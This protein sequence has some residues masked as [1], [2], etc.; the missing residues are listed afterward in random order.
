MIFEAVLHG[1][2]YYFGQRESVESVIYIFEKLNARDSGD[3]LKLD[4]WG[5]SRNYLNDN[6]LRLVIKQATGTGK[7]KTAL[8]FIYRALNSGL[9]NNILFVVDRKFSGNPIGMLERSSVAIKIKL[10][11]SNFANIVMVWKE[12]LNIDDKNGQ[13]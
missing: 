13:M 1:F 10:N 2:R 7:T 3:L 11:D 9:F 5:L 6:W 12:E 8:A 4:S